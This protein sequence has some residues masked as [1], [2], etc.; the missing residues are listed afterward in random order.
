[1]SSKNKIISFTYKLIINTFINYFL[2]SLLLDYLEIENSWVNTFIIFSASISSVCVWRLVIKKPWIL[3]IF[4]GLLT[5]GIIYMYN[6]QN[7][8]YF[9]MIDVINDFMDWSYRFITGLTFLHVPNFRILLGLIVFVLSLITSML[10]FSVKRMYFLFIIGTP[11][12]MIRWFQY[13]DNAL[14]HFIFYIMFVLMLYTFNRYTQMESSWISSKKI[15]KSNIFKSWLIYSSITC[16]SIVLISA[17]L[18]RN[19][20][21]VS[22]RWLDDKIQ[23]NFPF[24]G[25]WRNNSMKSR[26]YGDEMKFD[27]SFTDFQDSY[28]R[29]GGPIKLKNILV[30]TVSSKQPVYLKG[31]AKDFYTGSYWKSSEET[32]YEEVMGSPNT[33]YEKN[34]VDGKH[35]AVTITHKNIVTSTLFNSFIPKNIVM[36]KSFY[37]MTKSLETF[38]ENLVIKDKRYTV[39]SVNPYIDWEKV[40][41]S[42]FKF[43]RDSLDYWDEDYVDRNLQ[44]PEGL[45]DRIHLLSYNIS[46][47][48]KSDYEKV[49]A[50]ENYLRSNYKYSLS[51][52]ETPFN[53]DF[54]DYFLFELEEGYCTYFASSL[55]IMARSLGIP[56]RYVEGYKISSDSNK[57]NEEYLVY[58]KDAHAWP[59]VYIEGYGWMIFEPTPGYENIVYEEKMNVDEEIAKEDKSERYRNRFFEKDLSELLDSDFAFEMEF[60]QENE[61]TNKSQYVKA[62]IYSIAV[63]SILVLVLLIVFCFNFIRI[64]LIFKQISKKS[65]K[66]KILNYYRF[67]LNLLDIAN[68]GKDEGETPNEYCKRLKLNVWEGKYNFK[69]TTEIFNKARYGERGITS[70]E[71]ENVKEYYLKTEKNTLKKIGIIR[72]IIYKY[73]MMRIYK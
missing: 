49:K 55:V 20:I 11:I 29:L 4:L 26:G 39:F 73:F 2:I 56:A 35:I 8:I 43:D 19:F 22:S 71:F 65:Y 27:L 21:P 47:G 6:F 32:F 33:L 48:N 67:I 61:N 60:S 52:P 36:D 50:L 31:R 58:S 38:K 15:I 68:N 51:P 64:K 37:Y 13:S 53:K 57:T 7:S 12:F 72:F 10:V 42:N 54:V 70:E 40:K 44:I 28:K 34:K 17:V 45:P 41:A 62:I 25:E 23:S 46:R 1:M 66:E 24:L 9:S 18:P 30:M 14:I 59:E 3:G 16:I 69:N 5:C 63:F